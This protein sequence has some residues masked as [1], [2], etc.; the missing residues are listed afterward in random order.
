[1]GAPRVVP[2]AADG[3]QHVV[4][5]ALP[6]LL[7]DATSQPPG[8]RDDSIGVAIDP[9]DDSVVPDGPQAGDAPQAPPRAPE[10]HAS[11]SSLAACRHGI[12]CPWHAL[13]RCLYRHEEPSNLDSD[14]LPELVNLHTL[15]PGHDHTAFFRDNV[16]APLPGLQS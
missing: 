13:G 6:R 5:A 14:N 4:P 3:P 15:A 12:R 1:M 11:R 7:H 9:G 2:D 16:P 10:A 8:G